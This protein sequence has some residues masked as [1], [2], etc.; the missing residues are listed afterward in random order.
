MYGEVVELKKL[1]TEPPTLGG[2]R[3]YPRNLFLENLFLDPLSY[4]CGFW[5]KIPESYRLLGAFSL[6]NITQGSK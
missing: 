4:L 3:P 1:P 2:T 6:L 5:S